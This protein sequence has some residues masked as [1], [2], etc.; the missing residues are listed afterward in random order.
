[1]DNVSRNAY[2]CGSV[3][4]LGTG[5]AL[6]GAPVDN[7]ALF[8]RV[9]P[10]APGL[11]V[12]AVIATARRLAIETRHFSRAFI[13][14]AEAPLAGARNPELAAQAVRLALD[15]AGIEPGELGYLIGHTATP[16]QPLPS[17]IALVA[18]E[19]D[20][21]G[22]HVELR[23]ACTGFA[24]AL[25]IAFGMLARPDAR[26]VA[27]V[28][29][30]TGSLFFDPACAALDREQRVNL[31]QMGDGPRRS[32]WHRPGLARRA[33]E[34]RGSV[35]SACIGRQGSRCARAAQ[36]IPRWLP[37]RSRLPMT[38]GGLRKLVQRCSTQVQRRQRVRVSRWMRSTGSSRIR[39]AGASACNWRRTSTCRWAKYS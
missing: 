25:L 9:R 4:V 26:P 16:A 30:E 8:E 39:Q 12:R 18:D 17:N 33:C 15:E 19:L 6:P 31:T 14:R 36:T 38:I 13:A 34:P 20:Y 29:S 11:T 27:I 32:C 2:A 23:Q 37:H 28:G 3:A 35:R 1:M 22:P 7:H 24:N 10:L 5:F 21:M